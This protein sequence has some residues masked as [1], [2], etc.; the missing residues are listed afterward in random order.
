MKRVLCLILIFLA[1]FAF[2]E[3][4]KETEDIDTKFIVPHET[5]GEIQFYGFYDDEDICNRFGKIYYMCEPQWDFDFTKKVIQNGLKKTQL[6]SEEIE[7]LYSL[8]NFDKYKYAASIF[9][10]NELNILWI[11]K[12][13]NNIIY[14]ILVPLI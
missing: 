8:M 6:E 9:V 7:R 4:N 14:E 3:S 5:F 13:E 2:A 12:F 10:W 11:M 1:V